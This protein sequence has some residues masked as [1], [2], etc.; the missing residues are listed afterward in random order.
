MARTGS[1]A[2]FGLIAPTNL[3][4]ERIIRESEMSGQMRIR[5]YAPRDRAQALDLAP[6]LTDGVAPWRHQVA[7]QDAVVGWVR[8]SIDQSDSPNRGTYVAEADGAIVGSY[9]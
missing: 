4:H 3:C 2:F 6:R 7:A 9:P 5:A 8:T 1:S